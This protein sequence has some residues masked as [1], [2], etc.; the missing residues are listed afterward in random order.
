[1]VSVTN[2]GVH[3]SQHKC[4]CEFKHCPVGLCLLSLS[5]QVKDPERAA[6]GIGWGRSASIPAWSL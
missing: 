2:R 1:M 4:N 3:M 5:F 6:A